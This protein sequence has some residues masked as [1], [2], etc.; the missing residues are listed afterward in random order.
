MAILTRALAENDE[1]QRQ[2]GKLPGQLVNHFGGFVGKRLG[3]SDIA[4]LG[5]QSYL[6]FAPTNA[7]I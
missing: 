3:V 7:A 6:K 2:R 4:G 1:Q 5:R